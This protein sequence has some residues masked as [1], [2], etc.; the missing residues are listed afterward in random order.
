MSK[1]PLTASLTLAVAVTLTAC[2]KQEVAQ[3][4]PIRSVR[5]VEIDSESASRAR[6]F[7]GVS[8]SEQEAGLSFKVAGTIQQ[9]DVKVGDEL[10]A[11]QLISRIDD[12][13]YQLQVQQAQADLTRSSA[14]L[15]NASS[16]YQ[17]TRNLYEN[18]NASRNDLDSARAAFESAEAL[19]AA[20]EKAVEIARLNVSY[21]ELEATDACA[22]AE[23]NVEIGEN[24]SVGQQIV[25]VTCG[26]LLKVEVSVPENLISS[27]SS[28]MDADIVF[29][30]RPDDGFSGQVIEVGTAATGTTF[31]V[32]VRV[33]EPEGLRTGLAAQVTFEFDAEEAA[34]VV[35]TSAVAEDQEGRYVYLVGEGS[36]EGRGVISRQPVEVGDLVSAGLEIRS[37]V[38]TGDRVVTA[39]VSV[40]RDG[41]EVMVNP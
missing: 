12:S 19:V 22:V 23:V 33:T 31:P 9:L 2:E 1:I 32:S 30:S 21:T 39:G 8:R 4:A 18:Q 20:S 36:E 35:P 37:G 29:D 7:S 26:D 3:E 41:L 25:N 16:A 13:T 14:E 15:R 38:E 11:G 24:V 27:F 5:Y 10:A 6:T 40:I 28:G 34:I 17:R